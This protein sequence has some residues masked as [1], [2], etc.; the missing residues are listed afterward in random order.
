M[1]IEKRVKIVVR[2]LLR[3]SEE[4][5]VSLDD[6]FVEDLGADS[7]DEVELL[8]CLENEFDISVPDEEAEK[9]KTVRDAV[10]YLNTHVAV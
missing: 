7:L 5:E 9:I 8:M 3:F 2:D 4:E 1:N 10:N 6:N